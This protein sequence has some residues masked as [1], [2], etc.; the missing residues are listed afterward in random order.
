VT[1]GLGR[2]EGLRHV[3]ARRGHQV[4]V[5]D[6]NAPGLERLRGACKALSG[7]VPKTSLPW[8]EAVGLSIEHRNGAWWL[9]VVPELWVPPVRAG[10]GSTTAHVR[11][12]HAATA[13]FIRERRATRY[14]RDINAILD[15]WVRVLC[16]GRGP[17]EV[18]TWN[19]ATGQ[20][21]DPLVEVIGRT[22]YSRPLSVSP[23]VSRG[24]A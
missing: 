9:L 21:I 2:T 1:I 3:L 22:A 7:T 23:V 14:N 17:R 13:E 11:A 18:R 4:R 6:A 5:N 8:A 16:S 19:L 12:E 15:A 24:T 20:G 10:E